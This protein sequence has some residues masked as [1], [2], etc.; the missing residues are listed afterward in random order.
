MSAS[1]PNPSS[2]PDPD[3][4]SKNLRG[5]IRLHLAEGVGPIV[6]RRLIETFGDVEGVFAAGPPQW[7]RVKGIGQKIAADIAAVTDQ[8]VDEEFA[9]ADAHGAAILTPA[10]ERFPPALRTIY[11]CPALL[12]VRGSLEPTDAIAVGAVGSRSC[13][14]YGM[15]QAERFGQLLARAG[16]TIV[17]GG[18]RGIDT[19]CHRGALSAG[20]RTIA[21]M[22]CGLCQTY[23]PENAELFERIVADGRGA[24]VSE[25]PMRT[26]IRAGNFHSR[27]RIISGLS[28]GVLVV[29]AARRSG[30]LITARQAAEQGREV[31]ALPGRADSPMS[32][33]TN[34]LI[35][36]GAILATSLDDI[37]EHL[38]PVG[39]RMGLTPAGF[40]GDTAGD[41][42]RGSG[43]PGNGA[44]GGGAHGDQLP[45]GLDE[46]ETALLTALTGG[47]MNLDELVRH[48]ELPSGQVAAA[49]TML[50]LKGAVTQQPGN[51]FARKR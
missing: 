48:T 39:E 50:I 25:Q 47:A 38:G 35:R 20:G 45:P 51:I 11:D 34:S 30:A 23:P 41:G 4:D 29:E 31:F 16:F 40:A 9:L 15:E 14:H 37:L 33:G 8:Q 3:P 5:A 17:S 49:M 1:N 22:G 26:E 27:N 44:R 6:Y 13:T 43:T 24:I 10:D 18:A 42:T 7:R 32:A 2:D 12:Y 36:D 19:A 46:T 21:V 28:L